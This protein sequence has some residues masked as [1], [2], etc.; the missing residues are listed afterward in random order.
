MIRPII[1]PISIAFQ[2]IARFGI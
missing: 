2:R 1:N